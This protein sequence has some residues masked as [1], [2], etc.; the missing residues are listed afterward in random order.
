VFVA[1]VNLTIICASNL[2]FFCN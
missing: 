1:D 2:Q